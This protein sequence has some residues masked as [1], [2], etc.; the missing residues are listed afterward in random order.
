MKII[1]LLFI[2]L[3]FVCA[4]I[5]AKPFEIAE[6]EFKGSRV[7][8]VIRVL[9]EDAEVNIIATPDAGEKEITLFLKDINLEQAIK[10]ICRISNLWYRRDPG[11]NGMFQLMTT[12]EYAKNL[13][14]GQ[15]DTIKVFQL[16][17]PNVTAIA[18]AIE[19]LYGDRVEVSFGENVQSGGNQQGGS[20]NS[21]NRGGNSRSSR[22]SGG[23]NSGGRNGGRSSGGDLMQS[24]ELPDDLT[25]DQ[26]ESLTKKGSQVSIKNLENISCAK[27]IIHVTVNTE[28]N[29]LIVKTSN[30][31]VLKSIAEL[32]KNLDKPQTQ[33]MLEMKIVDIKV[34][35]DFSSLFKVE[36]TAGSATGDSLNPI[37]IGSAAFTGGGSL[38]YEYLSKSIKANLELLEKNNRVTVVSNPMIVASN[39]R[40]ATLFVGE[41][42][43][44]VRGY[45]IDTID[46]LNNTRTITTPETEIEEIGTTL[47]VTPHIN[48]D[49]TIHIILKQENSTLSK[50]A[51]LIP[52]SDG[53]GG[54]V[55]LPVDSITTAKLEGE[56][57]AKHGYTVAVGGLIRD[58][59][60]RNRTKVPLFA[61][62]PI[63]GHLFRSTIDND[64][65]SEMV[66]LIT[67]YILNQAG[68]KEL[69][70]P[71]NKYHKYAPDIAMTSRPVPKK[72][73]L[74]KLQCG[75]Y[76]SPKNLT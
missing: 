59:F 42:R 62:I 3:L 66:L 46:T 58:S 61:D 27:K 44:M 67:P 8:D 68:E 12:E 31:S 71:T 7:I 18:S 6:L 20:N 38:M 15:D 64:S 37:T 17:T 63:L 36:L 10:A 2:N 39:H 54:V 69:Y 45:S 5:Q 34:G 16:H 70:D 57:F 14:V 22:N 50:G 65:R 51:V 29:L 75:E 23:R 47:E 11:R 25:V 41:E 53:D 32:V 73:T 33:V 4:S 72:K 1:Y 35:E 9:A 19:D 74:I 49:G 26:F 76:C 60:S 21:S 48:S 52:I 30:Q 13:V 24:D 55:S 28:H 56:I 43:V 40:P